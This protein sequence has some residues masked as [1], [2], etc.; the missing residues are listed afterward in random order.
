M[1]LYWT[2]DSRLPLTFARRRDLANEPAG[3]CADY[4]QAR[5]EEARVKAEAMT[6]LEGSQLDA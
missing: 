1:P 5:A 2:I 6:N 4:C 3:L